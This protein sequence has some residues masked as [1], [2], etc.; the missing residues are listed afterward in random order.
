LTSTGRLAGLTVLVPESRE[1]DL[2]AGMLEGEG[3]ATL[4]CP[5]VSIL[6][7]ADPAPVEAWLR[8]LIMDGFDDLV[9]LTG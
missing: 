9:L 4:R 8:R 5:L 3:A 6:D 7:V 1:L 2:F